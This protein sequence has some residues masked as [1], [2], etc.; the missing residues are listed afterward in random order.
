[1][2]GNGDLFDVDNRTAL[3]T[4]ASSGIG[5]LFARALA[6]RGA[7]VVLTARRV[8]RIEALA[9]EISASGGSALAI[10]CDV[11]EADQVEE[12]VARAWDRFG[13][14]DILINN[15]GTAGDAGPCPERL[16]HALFEHTVRVN[17]LGVW[18][19]CQAAGARMLA[20]GRGGSII[21][22][23]SILGTGAQQN[24]PPAYQATKAGVINLTRTLAA[25]WGDRGVRVNAIAPGWFVTDINRDYLS[26][27]QGRKLTRDI[28][29]GRFGHDGDLDGAL[30]LLASDA[31]GYMAGTTVVVDG[32]QMV[33]LRG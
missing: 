10:P 22:I 12:A 31:G 15:A 7:K 13:R 24:Y 9:S 26:S 29:V 27:E 11:G 3:V 32:G 17:L 25:S 6:E 23:T 18:Y 8:D 4:G 14:V 21:N 5:A 16:P 2:T 20:D 28:P 19:G 1:L 30:L 33:A